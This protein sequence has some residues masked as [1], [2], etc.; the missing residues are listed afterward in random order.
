MRPSCSC[1]CLSAGLTRGGGVQQEN[2]LLPGSQLWMIAP[3]HVVAAW[4]S[5]HDLLLWRRAFL[6]A[7]HGYDRFVPD[8]IVL[9][10]PR[11]RRAPRFGRGAAAKRRRPSTCSR[12]GSHESCRA[13]L[14]SHAYVRNGSGDDDVRIVEALL[15]LE[16]TVYLHRIRSRHISGREWRCR[17]THSGHSTDRA[18][19]LDGLN[20]CGA[21]RDFIT[22]THAADGEQC[23][24]TG[25]QAR[26]SNDG[27]VSTA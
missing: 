1:R 13:G 24:L 12:R 6:D 27:D 14:R 23:L 16:I 15:E 25:P 17:R 26:A 19:R 4:K 22:E 21:D 7:V 9:T 2:T 10:D 3:A 20:G 11:R 8:R 18:S 5:H